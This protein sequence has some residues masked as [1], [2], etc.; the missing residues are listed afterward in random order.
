MSLRAG[1]FDRIITIE[2]Q[3]P[4]GDEDVFGQPLSEWRPI[5]SMWAS[6]THKSE[7]EAFAAEQRYAVRV[8]TFTLYWSNDIRETDRLICD[9]LRYGI[10]GIREI[11]FR[12][13]L[14]ISAEWQ[15]SQ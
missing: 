13:G 4:T 14:Q 1:S 6:K 12:E 5:A 9:G 8:V 10:K 3:I 11:G 7:D 2:R 15:D